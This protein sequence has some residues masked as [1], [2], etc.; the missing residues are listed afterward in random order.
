[1]KSALVIEDLIIGIICGLLLIGFTGKF[2]SLKFSKWVY[3]IAFIIYI[4]FIVLDIINELADLT[5][6]MGFIL[7]SILHNIVDIAIS[8][9]FISFFSGWSIPYVTAILVPFLQNEIMIFYTGI[10][11]VV[12]N[13][14]WIAIYPFT[15]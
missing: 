5:T 2:F 3:I 13:A 8:L 15:Y 11:L 6:H 10:F 1:M 7:L 4:P 12:T 14:I 9:T